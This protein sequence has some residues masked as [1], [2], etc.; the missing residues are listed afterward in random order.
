[1][2]MEENDNII[3][4]QIYLKDNV[5]D[6]FTKSLRMQFEKLVHNIQMHS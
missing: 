5:T 1:M 4:Q 2:D 3:I 6:L